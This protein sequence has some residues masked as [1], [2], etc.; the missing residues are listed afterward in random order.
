MDPINE[1]KVFMLLV[2]AACRCAAGYLTAGCSMCWPW[3]VLAA[4]CA[5][6]AGC[7]I[8]LWSP[9]AA[10]AARHN[11]PI[12]RLL[13]QCHARCFPLRPHPPPIRSACRAH[14]ACRA[15]TP[16]CFL[17]T[18][19]L[20]PDL[21]FSKDVTVLQIMNGSHVEQARA[22]SCALAAAAVTA[23]AHACRAVV[24]FAPAPQGCRAG[25][26]C[27]RRCRAI[28]AFAHACMLPCTCIHPSAHPP[29]LQVASSFTMERLLGRQ[30]MQA[31]TAAA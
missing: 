21:P 3:R 30:R 25:A 26:G 23:A 16:Q 6:C 28:R 4:A 15:G 17:L 19:K 11:W 22:C 10:C 2:D 9:P 13:L 12:R 20:L 18:P 1:R 27:G 31:L 5:G 24:P 29:A 7:N 8:P 14:P